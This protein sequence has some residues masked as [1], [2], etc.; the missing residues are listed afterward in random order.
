MRGRP[1]LERWPWL[2]VRVASLAGL[3]DRIWR[4][5]LLLAAA[6]FALSGPA[7]AFGRTDAVFLA[8]LVGVTLGAVAV[9]LGLLSLR[10]GRAPAPEPEENP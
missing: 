4:L 3:A 2:E 9:P 10:D 1:L 7:H 6:L 5:P 8:S